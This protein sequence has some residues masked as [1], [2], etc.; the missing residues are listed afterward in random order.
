MSYDGKERRTEV[1]NLA[2][3]VRALAIRF[4]NELGSANGAAEG[5]VNR[6]LRKIQDDIAEMREV[7]IGDGKS[8]GLSGKVLL[9]VDEFNSHVIQDRYLFGI[10][11]IMLGWI[12]VKLYKIS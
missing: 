7:I 10:T 2:T 5:S 12:I 8:L 4:D 6:H 9:I 3:E 11:I 1:L